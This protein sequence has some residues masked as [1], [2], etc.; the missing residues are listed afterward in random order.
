MLE[1][2]N[3]RGGN[4]SDSETEQMESP[5]TGGYRST[6]YIATNGNGTEDPKKVSEEKTGGYTSDS[7]HSSTATETNLIEGP[8][9]V[10]T[11]KRDFQKLLCFFLACDDRG[12]ERRLRAERQ[13]SPGK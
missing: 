13:S 7:E 8:K 10:C 1:K 3:P 4:T 9:K 11:Y 12:P 6:V 2:E 5:R